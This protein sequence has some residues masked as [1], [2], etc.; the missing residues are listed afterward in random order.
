MV[1]SVALS[2]T[3]MMTGEPVLHGGGEFLA[4]HQKI[5]VAID[6]QHRALPDTGFSH[7][8]RGRHAVPHEAAYRRHL[9]AQVAK[10][11]EAVNPAGIIARAIA[12][13]GV[14][15]ADARAARS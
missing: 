10:A 13:D 5:A 2:N 4:V 6:R 8:H 12:Q 7:R 15:A 11:V 14:S 9:G 1:P 3:S